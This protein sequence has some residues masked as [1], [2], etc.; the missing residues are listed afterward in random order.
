MEGNIQQLIKRYCLPGDED[1]GTQ[2]EGDQGAA[3]GGDDD[4]SDSED[5]EDKSKYN[6]LPPPQP[7]KPPVG[8][9]MRPTQVSTPSHFYAH[10]MVSYYCLY[11]TRTE[12]KASLPYTNMRGKLV[13]SWIYKW[14]GGR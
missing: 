4:K 8:A 7:G 6:N 3:K 11:L 1:E 2:D 5:D 13:W 10:C 14:E 9:Q 12:P